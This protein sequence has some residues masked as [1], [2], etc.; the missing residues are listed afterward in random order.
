M[1][2]T[3]DSIWGEDSST[4]DANHSV[5]SSPGAQVGAQAQQVT[6]GPWRKPNKATTG[7]GKKSAKGVVARQSRSQSG[8]GTRRG[9]SRSSSSGGRGKG[10]TRWGHR[11]PRGQRERGCVRDRHGSG[12]APIAVWGASGGAADPA[13]S[14]EHA[15]S[16]P[17]QG[18]ILF[19][20]DTG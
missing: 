11:W 5:W 18:A 16:A 7:D 1:T 13:E 19:T 14:L 15:S 2:S 9:D 10:W 20:K 17:R 6:Y 3:L 4:I 8:A 12:G